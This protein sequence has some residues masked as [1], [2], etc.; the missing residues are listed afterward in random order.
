MEWISCRGEH[1]PLKFSELLLFLKT[2][3]FSI[4]FQF[5]P[6]TDLLVSIYSS[7]SQSSTVSHLQG[8]RSKNTCNSRVESDGAAE[9]C[10]RVPTHAPHAT[11]FLSDDPQQL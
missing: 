1:F 10:E 3:V 9:S 5:L 6:L 8:T 11:S 7:L 4:L 2:G